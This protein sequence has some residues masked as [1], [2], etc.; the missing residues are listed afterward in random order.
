MNNTIKEKALS[1][2]LRIGD[3]ILSQ[4]KTDEKGMSWET[5]ASFNDTEVGW[6]K[7]E[8]LYNG[9]AGICLFLLEL[10][11]FTKNTKYL[12]SAL[13]GAKWIINF[14]KENPAYNYSFITGRLGVSYLFIRIHELTGKDEYLGNALEIAKQSPL[15]EYNEM[16][17]FLIGSSGIIL[18]LLH[19]HAATKEKTLLEIIDSYINHLI[20][21]VHAGNRGLYWDR[22]PAN[23]SGLCGFSHGAAGI[24]SVFLEL[25]YYFNNPSFYWI[26]EQAFNYESAYYNK[27]IN[28]WPDLRKFSDEE[29]EF[30]KQEKAFF[31][32]D[33]NVFYDKTYMNGW[34]HGAAGIGLSRIRA[35]ELLKKDIYKKEI[36]NCTQKTIETDIE[37]KDDFFSYI[38]CHGRGGN[39]NLFLESYLLFKDDKYLKF[40]EKI[41]ESGLQSR[42]QRK[43]YKSG[44]GYQSAAGQE[45]KSLMMGN[46][47]IGY[48]Y[49]RLLDPVNIPCILY[50]KIKNTSCE[51]QINKY[52]N[53]QTS[54]KDIKKRVVEKSF[55][56]TLILSGLLIPQKTEKHFDENRKKMDETNAF[57]RFIKKEIIKL[58]LQKRMVLYD[59]FLSESKV[60]KT[61]RG[62]KSNVYLYLKSV[63][64]AKQA[65]A[66]NALEKKDFLNLKLVIDPDIRFHYPKWIWNSN[67]SHITAENLKVKPSQYFELLKPEAAGIVKTQLS[68][69]AFT[70]LKLFYKSKVVKKAVQSII[71][72]LENIDETDK[73]KI[74][75]VTL[76]QIKQLILFQALIQAKN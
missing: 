26:A 58:P 6:A 3:E 27:T 61:D 50:P 23:I 15:P 36:D 51:I 22:K 5:M 43:I 24:A 2:A 63:V 31:K 1:E 49:L 11:N 34:C 65:E 4:A 10:Y 25:G 12:E 62:I 68:P 46:A 16:D 53:I 67:L 47:G 71:D 40:A 60:L 70:I 35:Y 8:S 38:L 74:M 44:Y 39:A 21:R 69:A 20:K 59:A 14:C 18:G 55:K 72:G 19:V 32:G 54:L 33:F 45:D 56:N 48:F 75:D 29:S 7:S 64:F 13:E 42:E 73:L 57:A 52:S 9:V 28:N 76:E 66:L 30:I 37:R 17:D 41:A